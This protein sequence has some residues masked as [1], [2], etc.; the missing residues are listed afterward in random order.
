MNIEV[1][2]VILNEFLIN[3]D[4]VLH[5]INPIV[6][7]IFLEK[8]TIPLRMSDIIHNLSDHLHRDQIMSSEAFFIGISH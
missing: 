5:S 7:E 2:C 6:F 3:N 1:F 4:E 8:L